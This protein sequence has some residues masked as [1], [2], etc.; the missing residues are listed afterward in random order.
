MTGRYKSPTEFVVFHEISESLQKPEN[1]N[2]VAQKIK[3]PF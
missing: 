3:L 1:S 2:M